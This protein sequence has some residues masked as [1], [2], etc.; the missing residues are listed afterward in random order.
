MDA[1]NDGLIARDV[2]C[3]STDVPLGTYATREECETACK[4]AAGC[5]YYIFGKGAKQGQCYWEKTSS[6]SCPEGLVKD[7]F[8]FYSRRREDNL[9]W[10]SSR[11][12]DILGLGPAGVAELRR[13]VNSPCWKDWALDKDKKALI[14]LVASGASCHKTVAGKTVK[15]FGG[16]ED[17]SFSDTKAYLDDVC[18]AEPF[19]DT[20]KPDVCVVADQLRQ[21]S[22][23]ACWPHWNLSDSKRKL[24]L[25]RMN[26]H[27][28][29]R[30]PETCT[31]DT[32]PINTVV[33][34]TDTGAFGHVRQWFDINTVGVEQQSGDKQWRK[35][36][37]KICGPGERVKYSWYYA[38]REYT[39]ERK[40]LFSGNIWGTGYRITADAGTAATT[41]YRDDPETADP[42]PDLYSVTNYP[43]YFYVYS[44][45]RAETTP[46]KIV[47]GGF[48][49][50]PVE[51]VCAEF[52]PN[53][54]PAAGEE[55][56]LE[57]L[58]CD[59][60][61]PSAFVSLVK[62]TTPSNI[63]AITSD[64]C[65]REWSVKN[66]LNAAKRQVLEGSFNE[67]LC[68]PCT[69]STCP[70]GTKIVHGT[71]AGTIHDASGEFDTFSISESE[72]SWNHPGNTKICTVDK[73]CLLINKKKHRELLSKGSGYSCKFTV[74]QDGELTKT[75]GKLYSDDNIFTYKQNTPYGGKWNLQPRN[76]KKNDTVVWIPQA[77]TRYYSDT[78]L[79][80]CLTTG[81]LVKIKYDDDGSVS[82][83]MPLRDVRR[84]GRSDDSIQNIDNTCW[85]FDLTPSEIRQQKAQLKY[86]EWSFGNCNI[87]NTSNTGR[88]ACERKSSVCN[89]HF[90]MDWITT[91]EECKRA[92][93]VLGKTQK[94]RENSRSTTRTY[95]VGVW[96][97]KASCYSTRRLLLRIACHTKRERVTCV[98]AVG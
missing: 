29:G 60:Q 25:S 43:A 65:W 92:A 42:Q 39:N 46:S 71:R 31:K 49:F 52:L 3:A 56:T 67:E 89:S 84:S 16:W 38:R 10:E 82:D 70:E 64:S 87:Y 6:P 24:I 90:G 95:R 8:D 17:M 63:N 30:S 55:I 2:E 13:M 37:V 94:Q 41:V 12:A 81:D 69:K 32:C 57:H 54:C 79:R 22:E 21:M 80:I 45:E 73:N 15:G 40:I 74:L 72:N 47:S 44:R 11:A 98:F 68:S 27:V 96:S 14:Q 91:E 5:T 62:S 33:K 7:Y 88:N 75:S 59:T 20:S 76:I 1:H 51:D 36:S 34:R 9:S 58:G 97:L 26:G 35:C 4:E 85:S 18:G 53:T 28:H 48:T 78:N 66:D 86:P 83:P 19:S 93:T 61:E 77:R 50:A 23:D